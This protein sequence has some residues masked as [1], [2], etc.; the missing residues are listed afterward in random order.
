MLVCAWVP[1]LLCTVGM[2]D[3]IVCALWDVLLACGCRH[4][5]VQRAAP[6][7]ALLQLLFK[8]RHARPL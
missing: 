2:G 3:E 7:A 8:V 4:R 1:S 6:L 5:T